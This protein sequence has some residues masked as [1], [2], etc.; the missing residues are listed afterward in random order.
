[1]HARLTASA[2]VLTVR[3]AP[4]MARL[5]LEISGLD[6]V[7]RLEASDSMAMNRRLASTRASRSNNETIDAALLRL[8]E[9]V[10]A[11][12]E[13]ADG[14]SLTL[15]RDGRLSTVAATNNTV[16]TMDAHQYET[17]E[18]PCLSAA[19][20]GH[21]FQIESLA[22]EARWP[23]FVPRALEEGI[24]SILSTPLLTAERPLGAL[25]IYSNTERAFGPHQHDL[26]ALFA[27]QASGIL[28]DAGAE[29]SD[30][31]MDKRI[32]DA[33][34]ARQTIARAQG[35][36]MAREHISAHN[37]AAA[38]HRSARAAKVAVATHADAI[39]ESTHD[40]SESDR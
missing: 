21:S 15:E 10:D 2:R 26:A 34:I 25:N 20:E 13:G 24:A 29:A 37:A 16:L 27:A 23:A 40:A 39:V 19:A 12:V 18:G 8:T 32:S 6:N 30:E 3:S 11:A 36:L 31:E 33:L 1:M 28:A 7:V 4:V 5:I 9:L 17:G 14:V 22:D 35:V 38:I